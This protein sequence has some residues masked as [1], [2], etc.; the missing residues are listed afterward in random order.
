MKQTGCKKLYLKILATK[1]AMRLW[2]TQSFVSDLEC[3]SLLKGF[4]VSSPWQYQLH[5]SSYQEIKSIHIKN[6]PA[7]LDSLQDAKKKKKSLWLYCS[8]FIF[9]NIVGY[10]NTNDTSSN[11]QTCK[12]NWSMLV[13][14]ITSSWRRGPCN[15]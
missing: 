14:N 8:P 2:R 13:R 6:V 1:F 5:E 7:Y 9:R 10:Q 15:F 3:F 11:M 4:R 12:L